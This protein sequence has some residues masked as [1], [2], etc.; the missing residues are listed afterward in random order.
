RAIAQLDAGHVGPKEFVRRGV[1]RN[2]SRVL[3]MTGDFGAARE[4]LLRLQEQAGQAEGVD[5]QEYA[6][7]LWQRVVLARRARDAVGGV[8]L[9]QESRARWAKLVPEAHPIFAHALAN[10][11]VFAEVRGDLATAELK[12]REATTRMEAAGKPVDLAATRATLARILFKRGDREGAR[13]L[14]AQALPVLRESVLPT[15][16][17]RAEA[18]QLARGLL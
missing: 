17:G 15:H 6:W 12:L 3:T 13:K 18:E 11:G 4:L 14:L 5:S 16:V 8:Q 10:E 2:Y 9:L 1:L 7:V